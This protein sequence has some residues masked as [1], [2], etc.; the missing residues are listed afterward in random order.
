MTAHQGRQP[1][2]IGLRRGQAGDAEHDLDA[3]HAGALID[4]L[5]LEAEDL[6]QTGP[7]AILGGQGV[8]SLQGAH[9]NAAAVQVRTAG[10]SDRLSDDLGIAEEGGNV[11]TQGG[12]VGLGGQH[13]VATLGDHLLNDR[14][15][16][17]LGI[18]GDDPAR[19]IESFQQGQRRC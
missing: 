12:L 13:V 11:V 10:R 7:A 3:A 18:A 1:F 8:G 15:L 14:F 17:E 5:P 16:R 19:Q 2:G 9:F 4:P 6:L